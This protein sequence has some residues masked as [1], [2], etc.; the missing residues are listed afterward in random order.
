MDRLGIIEINLSV[1]TDVA[2]PVILAELF[3]VTAKTVVVCQCDLLHKVVHLGVELFQLVLHGQNNRNE[4]LFG[5]GIQLFCT[6][7]FAHGTPP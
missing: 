3:G 1:F 7:F 2:L 6:Q 4:C 5:H